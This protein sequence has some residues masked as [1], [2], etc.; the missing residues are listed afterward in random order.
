MVSN[1]GPANELDFTEYESDGWKFAHSSYGMS[2]TKELDQLQDLTECD[3]PEVF[4]GKNVF[5]C[6]CPEKDVLLEVS[7]I[8]SIALSKFTKREKF[9]RK[10]QDSCDLTPTSQDLHLLN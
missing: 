1:A 5:L 6:W 7:P 8:D 9:M 4:Y 10:T 3:L 2:N